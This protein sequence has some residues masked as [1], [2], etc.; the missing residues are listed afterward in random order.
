MYLTLQTIKSED[1]WRWPQ[2]Y[3]LFHHFLFFFCVC[4]LM[5]TQWCP[6][7]KFSLS[8]SAHFPEL[9]PLDIVP[10]NFARPRLS[11]SLYPPLATF[12]LFLHNSLELSFKTL[13]LAHLRA[14]SVNGKK[15]HFIPK[16]KV[17][18]LNGFRGTP[19][20][21]SVPSTV[22]KWI[23]RK[24]QP[25]RVNNK[26]ASVGVRTGGDWIGWILE[27]SYRFNW[28]DLMMNWREEVKERDGL[29]GMEEGQGHKQK[30]HSGPANQGMLPI[31]VGRH[32]YK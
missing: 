29:R 11:F 1:S 28:W 14:S 18:P 21:E 30:L 12:N 26:E 31:H 17:K 32:L 15:F 5:M 3:T 27:I 10:W 24:H 8:H 13:N 20:T 7:R 19:H 25:I 23:V 9:L 22:W 16:E 2:K 6:F 4:L